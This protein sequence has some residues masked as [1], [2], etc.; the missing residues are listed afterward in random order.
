MQALCIGVNEYKDLKRLD[1]AIADAESIENAVRALPE[2]RVR[3]VCKNPSTTAFNEEG[4]WR[5]LDTD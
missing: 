5:F 1:N 3:P 4:R 2:S